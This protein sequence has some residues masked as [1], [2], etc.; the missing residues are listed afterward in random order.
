MNYKRILVCRSTPCN[1][2]YIIG[3]RWF[4]WHLDIS[5]IAFNILDAGIWKPRWRSMFVKHF[6]LLRCRSTFRRF[7][8]A[9]FVHLVYIIS[10]CAFVTFMLP[11]SYCGCNGEQICC[12][13]CS[14]L[15][16]VRMVVTAVRVTSGISAKF[17]TRFDSSF[18][19]CF[20]VACM[21]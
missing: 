2:E 15:P 9:I 3:L 16:P 6:F 10:V 4:V 12:K 18:L 7:G 21:S 11:D 8:R 14:L 1:N 5:S 13:V 19:L 20:Y 17:C